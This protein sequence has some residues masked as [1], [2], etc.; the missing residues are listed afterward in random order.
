ML[1]QRPKASERAR[2][3]EAWERACQAEDTAF[4]NVWRQARTWQVGGAVRRPVW[5]KQ[6]R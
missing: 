1:E 4:A 5:L 2:H 6:S 3:V